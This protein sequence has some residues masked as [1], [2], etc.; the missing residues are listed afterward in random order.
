MKFNDKVVG[1]RDLAGWYGIPTLIFQNGW[2]IW[3]KII[4]AQPIIAGN[5]YCIALLLLILEWKALNLTK[6]IYSG[7]AVEQ[8]L[9]Q[10]VEN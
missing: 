7:Y 4:Y 10:S 6:Y 5:V 1:W 8:G 2:C 9:N 3:F